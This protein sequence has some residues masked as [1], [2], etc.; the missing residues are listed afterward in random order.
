MFGREA[1]T[2]AKMEAK[3]ERK[4][5]GRQEM[6]DAAAREAL[7]KAREERLE[8]D[9]EESGAGES[10]SEQDGGIIVSMA[11]GA[12]KAIG[13]LLVTGKCVNL[14]GRPLGTEWCRLAVSAAAG[15][16]MR[17]VRVLVGLPASLVV[18]AGSIVSDALCMLSL[19]L[20]SRCTG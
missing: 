20:D 18:T 11:A 8:R 16:A 7:R 4:R 15:R 6:E 10:E 17:V 5:K 2:E 12:L 3:A 9:L 13:K 19:C 1:D 14:R